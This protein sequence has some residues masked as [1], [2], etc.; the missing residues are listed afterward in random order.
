MARTERVTVTLPGE[1]VREVDRREQNR[2][3]FVLEA[4]QHELERRRRDALR[5]S[6]EHPHPDG[7]ALAD[8]GFGEWARTLPEEDAGDLV[9]L[10]AGSPLRWTPGEGWSEVDE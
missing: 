5:R 1:V 10:S 8:T 9:D 6:I 7:A 4:I 2:S 3:R